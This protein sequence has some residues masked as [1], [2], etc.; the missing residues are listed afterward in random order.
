MKYQEIRAYNHYN[1]VTSYSVV[2]PF[3]YEQAMAGTQSFSNIV[4]YYTLHH[5]GQAWGD[6]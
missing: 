4:D 3:S 6:L 2:Y 1:Y 5:H